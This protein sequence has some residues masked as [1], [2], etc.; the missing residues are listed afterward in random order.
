[1]TMRVVAMPLAIS[2]DDVG[3]ADAVHLGERAIA[4]PLGVERGERGEEREGAFFAELREREEVAGE[5]EADATEGAVAHDVH[6]LSEAGDGG[7]EL[8]GSEERGALAR[9][10]D[11]HGRERS[12]RRMH[13]A[14]EVHSIFTRD[15]GT[16]ASQRNC[17]ERCRASTL[18]AR[19]ARC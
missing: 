3:E 15:N 16:S 9:A 4:E 6:G 13:G 10:K 12:G 2:P 5:A 18:E 17:D 1:M 8:G 7:D 19:R 14:P 11:A